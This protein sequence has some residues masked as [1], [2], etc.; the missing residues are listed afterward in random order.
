MQYFYD[1]YEMANGV[2]LTTIFALA[3]ANLLLEK[4][5]M[6]KDGKFNARQSAIDILTHLSIILATFLLRVAFGVVGYDLFSE[7]I[8]VA[9]I[10]H[11]IY[12]IAL[13]FKALG[14]IEVY[15]AIRAVKEIK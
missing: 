6:I 2:F 14:F 8:M 9:I 1:L 12:A 13:S 15:K 11:Y 5:I 7:I 4:V 10:G 3:I